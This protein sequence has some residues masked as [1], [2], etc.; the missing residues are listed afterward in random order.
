MAKCPGRGQFW[1]GSR[2]LVGLGP[3][4]QAVPVSVHLKLCGAFAGTQHV[5]QPFLFFS[6]CLGKCMLQVCGCQ[7]RASDPPEPEFLTVVNCPASGQ[8]TKLG[9]SERTGVFFRPSLPFSTCTNNSTN[10]CWISESVFCPLCY[11][12]CLP[13]PQLPLLGFLWQISLPFHPSS[14]L[15]FLQ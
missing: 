6:V 4:P 7:E 13:P 1:E 12:A 9:S 3:A 8:E 15:E 14:A 11:L 5:V 10:C 2:G